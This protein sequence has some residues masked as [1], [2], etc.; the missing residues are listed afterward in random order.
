MR[1]VYLAIKY[2]G[3][4]VVQKC[5]SGKYDPFTLVLFGKCSKVFYNKM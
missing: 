3:K 5:P 4:G 2:H 1:R